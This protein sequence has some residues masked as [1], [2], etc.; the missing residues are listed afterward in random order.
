MS[1]KTANCSEKNFA[2]IA[3]KIAQEELKGAS[4]VIASIQELI[5][6]DEEFYEN[7]KRLEVKKGN[8]IRY[9]LRKIHNHHNEEIRIIED[10]N[11]VHVEHIMPKKIQTA[12]DW[13]VDGDQ[14]EIYV[15]RFGNLT[16]LGQEYNR[17]A[18][19]KDFESKKEIYQQSEI[20]MT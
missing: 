12:D 3:Q 6:S 19:N 11:T 14:H 18:V 8:I 2:G 16:L 5:I 10:N 20:P 4:A 9:L 1:G 17:S 13:K 7:F 15:N